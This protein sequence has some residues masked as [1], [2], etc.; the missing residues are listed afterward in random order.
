MTLRQIIEAYS[1]GEITKA[2]AREKLIALGMEP[3]DADNLI[4]IEDGGD[5]VIDLEETEP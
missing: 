5:D 4:Y 1:A 2:E 3:A